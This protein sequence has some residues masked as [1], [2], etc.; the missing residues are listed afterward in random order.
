MEKQTN[1]PD[2]KELNDRIILNASSS[3]SIG[4]KTNLDIKNNTENNPYLSKEKE[5]EDREEVNRFF[6]N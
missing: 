1:M 6:T 2:F 5:I 4:A 3:P